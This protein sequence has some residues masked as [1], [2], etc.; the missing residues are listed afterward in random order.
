MENTHLGKRIVIIGGGTAGWITA[1]LVNH[2]LSDKGFTTTLI[3]SSDIGIIGVGEGSTPQL[4][5][6]F[7]TLGIAE[8]DWM[9]QC[10]ATF[11]NGIRFSNWTENKV[12]NSYFHPFPSPTDQQTARTFLVS[13]HQQFQGIAA[14][15]HPDPFFLAALL[16]DSGKSPKVK[17]G[18]D[19]LPLNYAYHFDSVLLGQYLR[20]VCISRG[21][22]HLTG[23][24][25]TIAQ[26]LNKHIASVTLSD[27]QTIEGDW[28]FDCS[29]FR[30]LLVQQQLNTRFVPFSD[31]LFNDA[32]IAIGTEIDA[33]FKPQTTATALDNGWKWHIPLQ[34]R[35][36]NGYV[37]SSQFCSADQAEQE[38][39]S[40]LP[41]DTS[42]AEARHL[43]MNVGRCENTWVGNAI[44]VGLSQGFIEP[45]EATALHIVQTT[46]E[47][48]ISAF[49]AGNYTAQ[50][51]AQFNQLINARI[52][53]IRDYIVCHYQASNRTDT[54]YWKA[55]SENINRSDSLQ[56]LLDVWDKG[57]NLIAEIE[58]QQ[59]GQFYPVVSWYCLLAGYGRFSTRQAA[60]I[61]DATAA[62]QNHLQSLLPL[63]DDHHSSLRRN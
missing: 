53:G 43:R 1:A 22:V 51:S 31:N 48:F 26:H 16:A 52:D 54:N 39:R 44:A 14:N 21:V 4:R 13:C 40:S 8:F 11:K 38:L 17:D 6:L 41:V 24:V 10:N 49:V 27:G 62:I 2:H 23:T 18:H 9:S 32:A 42:K 36:G 61:T 56:Y 47:Q 15:S 45:L 57:G 3:E 30:S 19:P 59:I 35:T 12:F 55:A 28:F 34:H 58:R 7:E 63:F 25:E 5:Q 60:E 50:H 37:Y 33:G 29:G 20:D 46:V